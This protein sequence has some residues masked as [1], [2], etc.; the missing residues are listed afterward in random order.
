MSSLPFFFI[1]L[2][3]WLIPH[4]VNGDVCETRDGEG[5]CRRGVLYEQGVEVG[6]A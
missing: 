6:R 2:S 4:G 1:R 5:E 3:A